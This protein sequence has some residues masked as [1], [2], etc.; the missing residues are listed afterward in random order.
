M[1][2]LICLILFFISSSAFAW[3]ISLDRTNHV[4]IRKID[5]LKQEN[6]SYFFDGKDL[7]KK[8]PANVLAAWKQIEKGP[9]KSSRALQC[10]SGKFVFIKKDNK[11][12]LRREGCTEG[13]AY[14]QMIK[15]IEE[16]RT[17]SQG[18]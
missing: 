18:I 11:K 2:H 14:G 5:I 3:E 1:K 4:G 9:V 8:L 13:D 6:G 16:L 10:E 7:G 12:T 17:Y 15:N